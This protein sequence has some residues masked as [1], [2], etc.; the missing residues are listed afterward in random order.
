MQIS[1]QNKSQSN[2]LA[3][4]LFLKAPVCKVQCPLNC[5][6][7]TDPNVLYHVTPVVTVCA[8]LGCMEYGSL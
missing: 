1:Q 8:H 4:S 5:H 3:C 2:I 6:F 7:H